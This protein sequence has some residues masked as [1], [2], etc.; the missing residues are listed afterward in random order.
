MEQFTPVAS[1]IGGVLIGISASAMLLLMGKI[2]G[3]SGI[4]GGLVSL[5][6]NDVIWRIAFVAGLLTGGF[7]LSALAP[8]L[9]Q[10]EIARS[11]GAL[12]LAGFMVGFGA[13]LGNGCTSGH[14]VCGIGR[15]SPRSII[16][17]IIFIILGAAGV[18]VVNHFFGGVI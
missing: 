15:F 14:G 1:L 8:Q 12:V 11:A 3:I 16:A 18:Y 17:T 9:F 6:E 4:V 10:V 7:I 5:K 13:R 2:A